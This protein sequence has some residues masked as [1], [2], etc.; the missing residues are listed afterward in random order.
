M[1]ELKDRMKMD[2]EL[3]NFSPRTIEAYLNCMKKYTFHYGISP[4]KLGDD[5]IRNYLYYLLKEKGASQP[6]INQAY[7][8]LKFCYEKTLGRDWNDKRIPRSKIPKKL[9]V[10]LAQEEIQSIF[11]S[12]NNLKHRAVFKTIYSGGL[13]INE[14][15][16]LNV[17][18]IDSKRMLI[19]VLGKGNKDRYTLLGEKA[20]EILRI[21][22]KVHHPSEWLFPSRIPDQPISDSTVQKAFKAALHKSGVK[23]KAS[24][25]TLRHSF[26]TH[27]LEA[28]TD[29]FYIQRLMGHTTAK[30]TSIYLHVT[31]KDLAK[32]KSPV[33]LLDDPDEPIL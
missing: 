14:A 2:M 8:A 7:S 1:G 17:T 12:T 15:T 9:P 33:D 27:L 32:V 20:L 16:H 23:K 26:A 21:Y 3:R 4:E 25:H 10:V 31:R 30:T 6:A 22:W 19:K 18:D 28:G 13:R 24:V 11:S 5:D 29:L